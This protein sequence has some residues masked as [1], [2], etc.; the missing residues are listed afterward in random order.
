[1][2]WQVKQS[3]SSIPKNI[4]MAIR[5][6]HEDKGWFGVVKD[7]FAVIVPHITKVEK[8]S[9]EGMHQ[10]FYPPRIGIDFYEPERYPEDR[11][12][13]IPNLELGDI[14]R[15]VRVL[16]LANRNPTFRSLRSGQ[17]EA[18]EIGLAFEKALRRRMTVDAEAKCL[19]ISYEACHKGT[20]VDFRYK[21]SREGAEELIKALKE[22]VSEYVS[23]I[24]KYVMVARIDDEFVK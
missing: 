22:L 3:R 7:T 15:L 12:D 20:E 2:T 14:A 9:F 23:F 10:Y 13:F 24:L 17:R 11:P 1:M 16:E 4:M 21:V 18:F 6:V 5:M 8:L 19:L